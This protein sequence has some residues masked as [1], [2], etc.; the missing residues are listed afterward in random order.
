MLQCTAMAGKP[1]SKTPLTRLKGVGPRVAE[2]LARLDIH[3]IEDLLFHLPLRYEDR[4]RVVPIGSLRVGDS[5]VVQGEVQLTE[6]KYG[7][8]RMLL[9]HL[10]DGTGRLLLRFFHF[11]AQ[12]KESLA[13]GVELRCYG[14]VRK[15]PNSLEMVHPEY[16]R[17]D[18]DAE[19]N[20]VE[21]SLTPIYP[22][23]EGLH[24]LTLRSLSEQALQLLREGQLALSEL[25]PQAILDQNQF[26]QLAQAIEYI[27]HPPPDA[28]VQAL[29]DREHIMQMRLAFEELL[30][31]TCSMRQLRN[32]TAEHEAVSLPASHKLKPQLLAALPFALTGAQQR[33]IQEIEHDLQLPQPMQRLVQG[34]V[35]SGKTLVAVSALLS[36]IEAGYQAVMMAPTEILAEQHYKNISQWLTPLGIQVCWLSGKLPT[37]ERRAAMAAIASGEAQVIVGTH[38][39]FQE[40]VM[41]DHLALVVI[42]EQHR[43]GVHQRLALREKGVKQG[44]Y[45]HQL[46]MT[47]TPIPRTLT[48][49][50]YADLDCSIIDELPP[51][52]KP[53]ETVVIPESRRAEVVHRVK[54]ACEQGRQVYWVCSLIEE[55]E[56]LQCQA[57]EDTAQTLAVALPQV[58]VGLVHGRLKPEQKEQVMQQFK[59]HKLDLLVA[60][61]VIEV[62]VDVP[63]ASLM[64][65][66]NAE[67]FG[68]AQ[69][70]QLRGRV[71]RGSQDS[72]CVLMYHGGLSQNARARLAVMRE[73][74]D[75]FVIAK[76]DLDLRGPG[77]ILGTRQTG[78]LQLRIA[79]LVKHQDLLPRLQRWTDELVTNQPQLVAQLINRWVGHN[80]RFAQV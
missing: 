17:V 30:A 68:L 79:D 57:A 76:K 28:P 47:A 56:A 70:H 32:L 49:T 3:C 75:G 53:V 27:H 37:A 25:L 31:Y 1:Q 42:D 44:K 4:T 77:E 55:S 54:V 71:G 72:A 67:R 19:I 43:F 24:Q 22:T 35:G 62:G 78:M 16:R 74:N 64:I 5:A 59:Q 73:T 34:D 41:F 11:N 65:I 23:T 58:R 26:P 63:N 6:I 45:P 33:V 48:M 18:P 80:Q 15:G 69:L 52:R 9:C 13:R 20:Q 8:K 21:E 14:E 66:E 12:Q 46:I 7:R 50:V 38:A 61:T 40:Q 2:K 10:S 39:L 29:L 60:T 51:G 36:A